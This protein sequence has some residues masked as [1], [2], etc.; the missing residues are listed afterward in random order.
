MSSNT[1]G[2]PS[3]VI[4]DVI[5]DIIE[6]G[7]DEIKPFTSDND[8]FLTDDDDDFDESFDE[9]FVEE[10]EVIKKKCD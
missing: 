7:N 2:N 9:E 3:V 5:E 4:E 6:D 1:N 10:N 8:F